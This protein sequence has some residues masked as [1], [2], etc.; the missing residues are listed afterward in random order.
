MVEIPV[1]VYAYRLGTAIVAG[2]VEVCVLML[3]DGS[4]A[5][6]AGVIIIVISASLADITALAIVAKM[7]VI[8]NAVLMLPDADGATIVAGVVEVCVLVNNHGSITSVAIIVSVFIDM[9][10]CLSGY[11]T[12]I[13]ARSTFGAGWIPFAMRRYVGSVA[14]VADM[15]IVGRGVRMRCA[16][17]FGVILGR[18]GCRTVSRAWLVSLESIIASEEAKIAPLVQVGIVERGIKQ[19]VSSVDKCGIPGVRFCLV[20]S[21]NNSAVNTQ[22]L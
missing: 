8:V 6:I 1:I 5:Y 13:G 20:F 21:D 11:H 22:A 10:K 2:V 18:E 16:E 15:V 3:P 12:A 17:G 7:I 14:D 9:A 4:A 19:V